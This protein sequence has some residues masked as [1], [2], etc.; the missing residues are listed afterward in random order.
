M[1]AGRMRHR[2]VIQKLERTQNTYGEEVE[3]WVDDVTVW[4]SLEP[5]KGSEYFSAQ[6]V[7][8][9]M[10]AVDARMYIRRRAGIN[11]A[12]NRVLHNGI[13]YDIVAVLDDNWMR[14]MQIMVR[15]AS[16]QQPDGGT[17]NA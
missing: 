6:D 4:A 7:P 2:I 9:R 3:A 11:P 17:V 14:H 16:A 12:T 10:A 15:A 1:N 13:V 8:Q 5:L